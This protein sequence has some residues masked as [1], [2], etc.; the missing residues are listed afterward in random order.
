MVEIQ[1]IAVP[2]LDFSMLSVHDGINRDLTSIEPKEV[3]NLVVSPRKGK[4]QF[5]GE[6]AA[7]LT[8]HLCDG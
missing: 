3:G 2:C 6:L 7:S 5:G 8:N 4:W 1:Q